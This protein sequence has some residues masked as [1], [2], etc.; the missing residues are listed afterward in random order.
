[1][2]FRDKLLLGA[3]GAGLIG[4]FIYSISSILLPFVVAVIFSYILNPSADKLQKLGISRATSTS[5]IIGFFFTT[6]IAIGALLVPFIYNQL[7]ELSQKI[8]EYLQL[9]NERILP[10]FTL[11]LNK[12]APDATAKA[13][14]SITEFSTY[15]FDFLGKMMANIWQSGLAIVNILSLLFVTPVVTFYVLRDW[16]KITG[17]I[18]SLLPPKY[19]PT[20]KEQLKEINRT[21]EGYLRGQIHVCVLLGAY[22][23]IGLT[24]AGLDFGF[25]VGMATGIVSFIPYVGMLFGFALG[26]ILAIFQF[27]DWLH[28][29]IVI[30][31]FLSGQFLE[32]NF[33]TPKLVGD[34]VGLHPVWIIFGMLAGA[35]MFGFTGI[36]LAVPVTAVIG[37]L[38]RFA[39][40]EYAN[41]AVFSGKKARKAK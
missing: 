37:V 31:V 26:V 1:M 12:I 20:I 14:A 13:M 33:V 10:E 25:V 36:L 15:I 28:I 18:N 22:Y 16:G 21:L 27:G 29:S 4:L 41:S 11:Y 39:V 5:I 9:A 6:L 19:A 23:A 32:G 7:V 17:K 34:K 8:P 38:T 30:A 35:A 40:T 3:I 24:L 2:T